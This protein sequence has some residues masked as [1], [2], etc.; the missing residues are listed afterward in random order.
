M[1]LSRSDRNG[2]PCRRTRNA[3]AEGARRRP[4]RRR[5]PPL[6]PLFA[7]LC[8][9][10]LA[11][12]PPAAAQ[13]QIPT[14]TT[15]VLSR[16]AIDESGA[17]NSAT[18]K[19]R[20]DHPFDA[21]I[22]DA[23]QV[24]VTLTVSPAAGAAA[25]DYRLSG[26]VCR[27]SGRMCLTVADGAIESA[28]A[29]TITA[30]DNAVDGPD[31]SLTISASAALSLPPLADPASVTLTLRD[32][33]SPPTVT[34]K[35]ADPRISENG[36]ATTVTAEL[37]HPS[38]EATTVT[39]L[40]VSGFW[41][42]GPDA[43]I[44]IPAGATSNPSDTAAIAAVDNSRDEA[45][46]R[47][48]VTA[49]ASNAHGIG[50]V[51]GAPL[52]LADDDGPPTRA[53]DPPREAGDVPEDEGDPEGAPN[54]IPTFGDAS[55]PA[56]RYVAGNGI[57]PLTLP[58]ATGGD[59]AL[60]YALTPSP[61]AGLTFDPAARTLSGVPERVS[62]IA[63]FT[64]SA[65]DRDGDTA[66]LVI[67]IEVVAAEDAACRRCDRVRATVLPEVARAWKSMVTEAVARRMARPDAAP[68]ETP[69]VDSLA[70]V[71]GALRGTGRAPAEGA[72]PWRALADTTS[73]A[74]RLG[75]TGGTVLW[76]EG[77]FRRLSGDSDAVSWSGEAF[78]AVLGVETRV[79]PEFRAG[80]AGS[81][82]EADFDYADRGARTETGGAYESRITGV[83]PWLGWRTANRGRLWAV[84]DYG[85]GDI[86]ETGGGDGARS[87]DA[88]LTGLA[89]GGGRVFRDGEAR[90]DLKGDLQAMRMSVDGE[91]EAF[92]D[93]DV[94]GQRLRVAAEA[95]RPFGLGAGRG[96]VLT[97]SLEVGLRVDG[98]DGATGAGALVGGGLGYADPSSRLRIETH[99]RALIAHE[100]GAE[101]WEI[102][103]SLEF[104]PGPGGRGL[105]FNLRPSLGDLGGH[106]AR[107]WERDGL[108]RQSDRPAQA[109]LDAALSWGLAAFAGRGMVSPWGGLALAQGGERSWRLGLVWNRTPDFAFALETATRETGGT[110]ADSGLYATFR[111][112]W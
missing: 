26:P 5:H 109:R 56:Q 108:R 89:A 47:A 43:T 21:T 31:K 41:T 53:V 74:A 29:L 111:M 104:A 35:V 63:S 103:G 110:F 59:G 102:G 3:A 83:H 92:R 37:S 16:T 52:I 64:L 24:V 60:T 18:V 36:D 112:T 33:E 1:F 15:L 50:A 76:A 84:L 67:A 11:L 98:G 82:F 107:L 80:L 22:S 7:A 75:D 62:D 97:P 54:R 48:T 91:E 55:T 86:V 99:G 78:G 42:A 90:L 13:Q 77:D 68:E 39:V 17:N 57:D 100:G 34:L 73:L 9:V 20:L 69:L 87:A 14:Q 45:D 101:E 40:P 8:A 70:S 30:V 32:D 93:L 94:R 12:A 71:A 2:R 46:R 88:T 4:S 81:R 38:S 79:G 85:S 23:A 51:T 105:S 58:E 10:P 28:D 96:P 6:S 66:R 95:S 27:P 49:S 19:V 25:G 72:R 44:A 61:P 106:A 65:T